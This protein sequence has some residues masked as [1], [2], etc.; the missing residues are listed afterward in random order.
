VYIMLSREDPYEAIDATKEALFIE[1]DFFSYGKLSWREKS[2]YLK[3]II[4]DYEVKID[5]FKEHVGAE[6]EII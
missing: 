3:K 4:K 5:E 2:N 6:E 1:V